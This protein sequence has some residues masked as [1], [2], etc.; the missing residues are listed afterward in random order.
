M[1]KQ[2]TTELDLQALAPI[3]I[4]QIIIWGPIVVGLVHQFLNADTEVHEFE[5]EEGDILTFKLS[6]PDYPRYGVIWI[7]SMSP[8]II[9]V[10]M[11]AKGNGPFDDIGKIKITH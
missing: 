2:R 9:D 1:T 11:T 10:Y 3:L 8:R 6:G 5:Y 4:R 7:K